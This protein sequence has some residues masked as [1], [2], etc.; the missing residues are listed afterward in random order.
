MNN[1]PMQYL[2]VI[3]W[4]AMLAIATALGWLL[5]SEWRRRRGLVSPLSVDGLKERADVNG[6]NLV[7][8][9]KLMRDAAATEKRHAHK[10]QL[11]LWA[12]HCEQT[13]LEHLECINALSLDALQTVAD[14]PVHLGE[15]RPTRDRRRN[16]PLQPS[17]VPVTGRLPTATGGH[18]G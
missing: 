17:P 3:A 5:S 12:K 8:I 2:I 6:C 10:A 7:R 1:I 14:Q 13:A 15:F 18:H 9:A 11:L 4:A 16:P